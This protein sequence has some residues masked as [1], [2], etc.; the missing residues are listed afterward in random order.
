MD[1][2]KLAL[3][4][5]L[6]KDAPETEILTALAKRL[7]EG[8]STAQALSSV[9]KQLEEHGFKLDQGKLLKLEID[10]AKPPADETPLQKKQREEL[11]QLKLENART[12]LSNVKSE[13]SALIKDGKV[14]P[15]VEKDLLALMSQASK[16]ETLSLSSDGQQVVRTAF[17]SID[18]LRRILGALPSIKGTQL[19][20]LTGQPDV[21]K[22]KRAA[23]SSKAKEV[24]ARVAGGG[25][26]K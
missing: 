22:E 16:A 7:D 9:Q 20:Q 4:L 10:P 24:A 1:L 26:K 13:V 12:R 25:Q 19:S 18:T 3:A 2:A 11:E 23:L 8:A 5:G 17:D 6:K 21:D 15:A 14:P